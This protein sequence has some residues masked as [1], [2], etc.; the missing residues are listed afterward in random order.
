MTVTEVNSSTFITDLII[1]IR[2]KLKNNIENQEYE[3]MIYWWATALEIANKFLVEEL[4]NNQQKQLTNACTTD[5]AATA[6]FQN[7]LEGIGEVL[8]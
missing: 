1:L 3:Y 5:R 7:L 8:K 6:H 2:D 4:V